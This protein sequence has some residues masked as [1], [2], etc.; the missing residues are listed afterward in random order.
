MRTTLLLLPLLPVVLA[1]SKC[2]S[3]KESASMVCV[4]PAGDTVPKSKATAADTCTPITAAVRESV[5]MSARESVP[6]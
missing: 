3:D 1:A 6:K 4:T 2:G 5:P